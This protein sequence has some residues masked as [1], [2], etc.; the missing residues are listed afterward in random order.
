MTI[1]RLLILLISAG[2]A[3]AAPGAVFETTKA[4]TI[5]PVA[6]TDISYRLAP[7]Q[8]LV[9]WHR[10]DLGAANSALLFDSEGVPLWRLERT[11]LVAIGNGPEYNDA[12]MYMLQR[13]AINARNASERAEYADK[14]LRLVADGR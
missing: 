13:A 1:F 11:K 8:V 2:A 4:G 9:V 5:I 3:W 7:G 14:L 6:T 12:A 10:D